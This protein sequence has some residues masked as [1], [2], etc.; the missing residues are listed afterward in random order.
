MLELPTVALR[1]DDLDPQVERLRS[2][3]QPARTASPPCTA[4]ARRRAASSRCNASAC[5]ATSSS[6]SSA[7]SR[8]HRGHV[9]AGDDVELE[10]P[11]RGERHV[12]D[13]VRTG[14][15]DTPPVGQL[16]G[17]QVATEARAGPLPCAVAALQQ[18]RDSWRN[19]WI[20]VDLPVRVVQRDADLFAAIF[21]RQDVGHARR[22]R[23]APRCATTRRPRPSAAGV[24]EACEPRVVVAAEADDLAPA[25]RGLARCLPRAMTGIGCRR[26]RRRRQTPGSRSTCHR[27]WG[28][29]GSREP[30][31]DA[32]ATGDASRRPPARPATHR[33][34]ARR[35]IAPAST[36][37]LDPVADRRT[38]PGGRRSSGSI[39]RRPGGRC[40]ARR[41]GVCIGQAVASMGLHHASATTSAA[42]PIG[43]A[44][45]SSMSPRRAGRHA[46]RRRRAAR[47]SARSRQ[48]DG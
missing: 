2:F 20:R 9:A 23:Q 26:R 3:G 7:V 10:R 33:G 27:C 13:R 6:S 35:W 41:A 25:S 28:R 44:P 15:D 47:P 5:S 45:M 29:A 11:A 18:P 31:A 4:R 38:L 34:A 12:G 16:L 21:E 22:R 24:V 43:R 14:R 1:R 19:E 48:P 46:A 39:C 42:G 37:V 40:A 36:C 8:A 32:S 30:R 17:E